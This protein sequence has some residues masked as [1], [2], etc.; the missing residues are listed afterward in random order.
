MSGK[1]GKSKKVIKICLNTGDVVDRYDSISAAAKSVDADRRCLS[2]HMK[3]G[4]PGRK[5]KGF[6]W[7]Y[8]EEENYSSVSSIEE[9]KK[10]RLHL[11]QNLTLKKK[12]AAEAARKKKGSKS[13][14]DNTVVLLTTTER[15]VKGDP[16]FVAKPVVDDV[17]D[18]GSSSPLKEKKIK[19]KNMPASSAKK[20]VAVACTTTPKGKK[21]KRSSSKKNQHKVVAAAA[22][23]AAAA[24][25]HVV[26][27]TPVSV[28]V[29][30]TIFPPNRRESTKSDTSNKF[31]KTKKVGDHWV[32]NTKKANDNDDDAMMVS[33]PSPSKKKTGSS[34]HDDDESLPSPPPTIESSA[35]KMKRKRKRR[36][37]RKFDD[38]SNGDSSNTNGN[39]NN[40]GNAST[41]TNP[42]DERSISISGGSGGNNN[43]NINLLPEQSVT[44][45]AATTATNDENI[46]ATNDDNINN[47]SK[48]YQKQTAA[49]QAKKG[50]N[51]RK[52][53]P[54]CPQLDA[55][56]RA[57]IWK[58]LLLSEKI[59][60]NASGY[61]ILAESFELNGRQIKDSVV[62]GRALARERKTEFTMSLLFIAFYAVGGDDAI[63]MKSKVLSQQIAQRR[64]EVQVH[65]AS[66]EEDYSSPV[67]GDD[68]N[69]NLQTAIALSVKEAHNKD[70]RKKPAV[71]PLVIPSRT[72]NDTE[73][74]IVDDVVDNE[75][76]DPS[77]FLT[78]SASMRR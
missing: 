78:P 1:Q 64:R 7:N 65:E 43:N 14:Q 2:R 62:V 29:P 15:R 31:R 6:T 51:D 49:A 12:V 30:V 41:S 53:P 33:T 24:A 4:L 13:N 56:G 58:N 48:S 36:I 57:K 45:A 59:E 46:S 54:C 32:A 74:S 72:T 52:N 38:N 25:N 60:T 27:K 39:S 18:N 66:Y 20:E 71:D 77:S 47:D 34:S 10:K 19:R 69:E 76:L 22:A 44:A 42:T 28:P 23:A 50:D 5:Y 9:I 17:D 70:E 63:A 3:S 73:F 61:R 26:K 8:V 67:G 35:T 37:R 40:N 11:Q 75:N 21:K 55:K 16:T 68:E